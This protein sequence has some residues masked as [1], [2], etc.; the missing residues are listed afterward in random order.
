[1]VDLISYPK[2]SGRDGVLRKEF[3]RNE[4]TILKRT[5]HE[6]KYRLQVSERQIGEQDIRFG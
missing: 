4:F 3:K 6:Q 2:F 1:M 5:Y